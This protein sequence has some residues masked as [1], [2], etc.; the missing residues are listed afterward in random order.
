MAARAINKK[1]LVLDLSPKPLE[2]YNETSQE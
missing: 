1:T 2:D